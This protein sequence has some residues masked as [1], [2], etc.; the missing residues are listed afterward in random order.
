M[1]EFFL[2]TRFFKR[3]PSSGSDIQS[4]LNTLKEIVKKNVVIDPIFST[5]YINN[6]TGKNPL[7]RVYFLRIKHGNNNKYNN[8]RKFTDL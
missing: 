1:S 7:R 6:P 8:K 3:L 5:W 2:N 4:Q